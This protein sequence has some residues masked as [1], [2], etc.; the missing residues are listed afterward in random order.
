M[1]FDCQRPSKAQLQ[2]LV[3]VGCDT[4][5]SYRAELCFANVLPHLGGMYVLF[6]SSAHLVRL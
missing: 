3:C 6:T 5:S 1:W 2:W 4:D